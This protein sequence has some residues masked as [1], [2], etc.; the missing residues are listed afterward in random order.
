MTKWTLS[1][2]E[3]TDRS[4]REYLARTGASESDLSK[5]VD[6]TMRGEILRR[7]VRDIQDRNQDLSEDEAESLANEAVAWARANRP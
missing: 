5:F 6:D 7:V 2:R 4:V 3:E 1:I